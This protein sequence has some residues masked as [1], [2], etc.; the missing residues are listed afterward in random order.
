MDTAYTNDQGN[1]VFTGIGAVFPYDYQIN[2]MD[3]G[4]AKTKTFYAVQGHPHDIITL[5]YNDYAPTTLD[6]IPAAVNSLPQSALSLDIS[7]FEA[8]AQIS[9]S[10]PT[11]GPVK[12]MMQDVLGRTVKMILDGFHSQGTA[13]T[14]VPLDGL[15]AGAYYVTLETAEGSLTKK[16]VVIR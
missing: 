11:D 7:A 6:T 16:F 15:V 5:N 3:S 4:I 8:F 1:F 9:Y 2:F 14:D 12:L 10:I 13:E